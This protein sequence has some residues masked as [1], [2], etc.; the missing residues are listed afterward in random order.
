MKTS[1]LLLLAGAL[2]VAAS[3]IAQVVLAKASLA[4][5]TALSG[6]MAT[7]TFDL[8]ALRHL[9]LEGPIRL[10]L[11]A[12]L[13]SVTVEGDQALIAELA[14][15]DTDPTSLTL[16]VPRTRP[17]GPGHEVIVRVSSQVLR[18]VEL[19]GAR[20]VESD[21]PLPYRALRL[22][23]SGGTM[24]ALEFEGVDSL[25]VAHSGS[26]DG[27]IGGRARHAAF[28]FSGSSELDATRLHSEHVRV[29]ASGSNDFRIHADST[30][31]VEA[32]GSSTVRYAGRPQLQVETSGSGQVRML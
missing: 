8:P 9:D 11:T 28:E 14:D 18:E 27:T 24:Y 22:A 6:T 17:G 31:R 12:G 3:V 4:P 5:A 30:L 26:L 1:N 2:V 20:S 16:V 10:I 13:P 21:G 19:A 15:R 32:S 23:S 25:W 29:E 7:R